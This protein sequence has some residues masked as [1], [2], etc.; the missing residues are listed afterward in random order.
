[1]PSQYV[2]DA[3]LVALAAFSGFLAVA[4]G[5][6]GAHA[7]RTRLDEE[8]R[9]TYETAVH[10]QIVHALAALVSGLAVGFL[11]GLAVWAGWFFLSGTVLFSGSLYVLSLRRIRLLG[12]VT[13]F[14]GLL[15]LAGWTLLV[16]G[17]LH[18]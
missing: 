5:A 6:F 16:V 7:L 3:L 15:F 11:G 1:M 8:H 14:G 2:G 18:R 4:L 13:P 9:H 10:Y 12:P 17:A